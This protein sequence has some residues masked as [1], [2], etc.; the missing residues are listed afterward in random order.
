MIESVE[1]MTDGEELNMRPMNR[2]VIKN[3]RDKNTAIIRLHKD[4]DKRLGKRV[5]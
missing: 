2:K 5:R 1:V 4:A 3:I